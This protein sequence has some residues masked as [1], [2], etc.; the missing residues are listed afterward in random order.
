[1]KKHASMHHQE[2]R[3]KFEIWRIHD[4]R[5]PLSPR[6]THS[7]GSTPPP[8]FGGSMLPPSIY[9]SAGSSQS[10]WNKPS[11][12]N[13][14]DRSLSVREQQQQ[15]EQQRLW[16]SAIEKKASV[17]LESWAIQQKTEG[18]I[19][20]LENIDTMLKTISMDKHGKVDENQ[21]KVQMLTQRL[22]AAQVRAY[23]WETTEKN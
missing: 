12:S 10:S 15:N 13:G 7:Q 19:E 5:F 11:N 17:W 18:M 4:H 1:M 20:T 21:S 22:D 9:A 2:D 6:Q 8:M 14:T 3:A 16:N 23:T